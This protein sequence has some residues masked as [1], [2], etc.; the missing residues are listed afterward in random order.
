MN[1]KKHKAKF[2]KNEKFFQFLIE[3]SFDFIVV[4]DDTGF[5]KYISPSVK[6]ISKYSSDELIGQKIFDFIYPPDLPLTRNIFNHIISESDLFYTFEVSFVDKIGLIHCVEVI[7]K[8]FLHEL[9]VQGIIVNAREITQRKE[10]EEE[11]RRY[12]QI[13]STSRDFMALVNR[14][15]CYEAV[16]DAYLRTHNK[17]R[18]QIVGHAIDELL[19][20]RIF[21]NIIQPHL[22]KCFSGEEVH[23]QWWMNNAEGESRC[24]DV[25]YCPY[26]EPDGSISGAVVNARDI[27]EQK[28]TEQKYHDLY[29]GLR[30]GSAAVDMNGTIIEFNSAFKN[31]L[32]YT[33]EEIYKLT[34]YDITPHKWHAKEDKIIK[35]QVLTRGYSNIYEKEYIRKNGT[36]FPVE[37]RT[38]LI[39]N[40]KGRPEGMWAIVRDITERKQTEEK[41]KASLEEKKVLLKEIHHRVKNN[42]QIISSLLNLQAMRIKESKY[43]DIFT[44]SHD[45]IKAMALIHDNLY[46]S[47]NLAN[48]IFSDY[49]KTLISCLYNSYEIKSER[50]V[51]VVKV[52]EISIE[53]NTALYCGLIINELVTNALKHAFPKGRSGKITVIFRKTDNEIEL[54]VSDN[55]IG[56]PDDFDIKSTDSLG[57]KLVR[58]LTLS[59]LSGKLF[60]DNTKG[61]HIKIIF[62]DK[63]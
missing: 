32:G 27:T 35:E 54:E 59:Q 37:I 18:R 33:D 14:D 39:E 22:D 61:A 56:I 52:Q 41:I 50:I 11:V 1:E 15:Y 2:Q 30:D 40:E 47:E 20:P 42:L 16:S 57:L 13:M 51:P 3:N 38:Y 23:Y 5:I 24:L 44:K 19:G 4:L 17:E 26:F 62:S 34:Y 29:K 12:K 49:I 25:I 48:I 28:M 63:E 21:K 46:R 55:G 6:K 9:T 60:L 31:M 45:R 43:K 36:I 7:G 10:A 53:V 58:T 8:N